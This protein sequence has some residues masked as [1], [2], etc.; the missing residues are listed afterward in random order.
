MK[1]T[2]A[3]KKKAVMAA[4]GGMPLTQVQKKFKLN[5]AATKRAAAK[6]KI[7]LPSR[8]KKAPVKKTAKKVV[9]KKKQ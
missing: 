4:K 7:V 8:P 2:D 1:Y 5:P 9:K 3:E 6:L